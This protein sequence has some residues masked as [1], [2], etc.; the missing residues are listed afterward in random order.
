MSSS[1]DLRR[2]ISSLA[3]SIRVCDGCFLEHLADELESE[4]GE[5]YNDKFLEV[6]RR[7]Y[8]YYG[9][10]NI[11]FKS[12]LWASLLE[13]VGVEDYRHTYE[14]RKSN[15]GCSLAQDVLRAA[16]DEWLVR[17][18]LMRCRMNVLYTTYY[19]VQGEGSSFY[20]CISKKYDEFSASI[21]RQRD[22]QELIKE[23]VCPEEYKLF[24]RECNDTEAERGDLS[25]EDCNTVTYLADDL[26]RIIHEIE[27]YFDEDVF[28]SFGSRKDDEYYLDDEDDSTEVIGIETST[29]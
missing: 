2:L 1:F 16:M 21:M 8:F 4:F 18:E 25:E 12:H 9:L 27:P 7:T 19:L 10:D 6:L 24:L 22:L 14:S 29:E 5:E 11:K 23:S 15:V 17:D 26:C 28:P 3:S 20:D 13:L